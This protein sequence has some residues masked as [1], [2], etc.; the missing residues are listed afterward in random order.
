MKEEDGRMAWKERKKELK[1]TEKIK[2][3]RKAHMHKEKRQDA[4]VE[5]KRKKA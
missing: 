4:S 5:R 3:M 1:K 2:G